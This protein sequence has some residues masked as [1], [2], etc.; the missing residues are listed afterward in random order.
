MAFIKKRPTG[1]Q[2]FTIIWL[3]QIVS[4]LGS[5]MTM[6]ALTIWAWQA[7]GKATSLALVGAFSYI[8]SLLLSPIAGVLVDRWN[9]KLVMMFSD[10][11]SVTAT[12]IVLLLYISNNLQIW[13]LYIVAFLAGG[14]MAFQFPAFTAAVTMMVPKDQYSRADAMIGV[15]ESAAGILAPMLAAALLGVIGM[16]GIISI[17]VLTFLAAFSTLLW[18]HVPQPA[19]TE[20]DQESQASLWQDALYGFKYIFTRPSLLAIQLIFFCGNFFESLSLTII[21]PM[22]LARTNGSEIMLGGIQS[23]GAIGG[24]VGGVL[25]SIWGGPKN[26]I[27][28]IMVGWALSNVLGIMLMGLG[29]NFFIWA[30]ASI[31]FAFL[32]PLVD[33]L[34]QAFWQSKV[35]P[36][37]QGRVFSNRLM[38]IQIPILIAQLLAGPLADNLLEPAMLPEGRLANIFGWLVSTGSGAGMSLMLVLT[39]LAGALIILGGYS[40]QIVR[41]AENILPDH[42]GQIIPIPENAV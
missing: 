21:A 5:S 27:K 30:F 40:I 14:F 25:M 8:P 22:I 26:K 38:I 4:L 36:D 17:D 9:R 6:F 16:T 42:D 23:C 34:N 24:V 35:A 39:G 29:K 1:L 20:T 41:N 32:T 28:G 18:V 37:L 10:L 19:R 33:G 12:V 31:V 13:H 11:G 7:T 3:G 15:A 2:G